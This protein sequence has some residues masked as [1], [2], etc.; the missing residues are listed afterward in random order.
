MWS[1]SVTHNSE[2]KFYLICW[3]RDC[4]LTVTQT[5]FMN[6]IQR[7]WPKMS[8]HLFYKQFLVIV[9]IDKKDQPTKIQDFVTKLFLN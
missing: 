9:P 3:A 6:H 7:F 2:T 8:K 1:Q 4:S 5:I